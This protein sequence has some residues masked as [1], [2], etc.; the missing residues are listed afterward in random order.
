M[1]L[2]VWS[3]AADE[4]L[5]GH[6]QARGAEQIVDELVLGVSPVR[7]AA[8]MA[9]RIGDGSRDVATLAAPIEDRADRFGARFV[10]PGDAEWP[11]QVD[12]LCSRMPLG[13]WVAGAANLRAIAAFSVA[14]VGARS[15]TTYGEGVGRDL[16][17]DLAEAQ[18]AV[19]SGGAFGI[20]AAAHRGALAGGGV[21]VCVLAG[22]VD[23]PYPRAHDSLIAR[24]RE[25]GVL[26]SE[27]SLGGAPMRQRFLTRNRVIG[28]LARGTVVV[29]AALRSG[30]G[31]TAREAH[32]LGR[33]VMA[34]PGPV[35]S[36]QSAGCHA[37]IR[38][39]V[40]DLV[41]GVRDVLRHVDPQGVEPEALWTDGALGVREARVLD[42]VPVRRAVA[43]ERIAATAGIAAHDALAALGLLEADGLVRR[44]STGW[45]RGSRPRD[46]PRRTM[47]E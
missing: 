1:L 45:R 14:V 2:A 24:I 27:T 41:C 16:G 29:E 15:A 43:A 28:A 32:A 35:T 33:A 18:W 42:A 31:T 21:T 38:D 30:S 5:V 34:I 11:T 22:G 6:V 3:E 12:D 20:D 8:A 46:V 4:D 17:A 44:E 39:G 37:L 9:L 23:V 25:H 7:R 13:L 19:V 10:I 36:P 47:V 40:A 26:V